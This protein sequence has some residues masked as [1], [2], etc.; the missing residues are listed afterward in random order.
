M[1]CCYDK[2]AEKCGG[3]IIQTGALRPVLDRFGFICV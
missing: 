2:C 3:E 1:Q